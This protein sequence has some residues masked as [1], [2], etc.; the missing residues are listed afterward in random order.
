MT[1][2]KLHNPFADDPLHGAAWVG[3]LRW[4]AGNPEVIAAY[5]ADTGDAFKPALSGINRMIDEDSGADY[6]FVCRFAEW[7]TA[8]VYGSPEDLVEESAE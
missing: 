4:A 1:E 5:R 2:K 3:C 8:N 7:V 6:A